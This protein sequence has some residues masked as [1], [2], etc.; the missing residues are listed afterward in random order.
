[1]SGR[2][3]LAIVLLVLGAGISTALVFRKDASTLDFR[4]D[5]VPESPFRERVERRALADTAWIR[6]LSRGRAKSV[7]R[8]AERITPTPAS[9][10]Q[11]APAPPTFQKSFS[12]VGALL[13]PIDGVPSDEQDTDTVAGLEPPSAPGT[14]IR[15]GALAHRVVDGDTLSQLAQTYLGRSDRYLEIFQ[16]NRDQL[17]SPDLLPIGAMLKIPPRQPGA[18]SNHSQPS[19]RSA[20]SRAQLQPLPISGG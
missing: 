17:A 12:P 19:S 5:A 11:G 9:M 2:K 20:E 10:S 3:R 7:E 16:A 1:M 18:E 4:Q 8:P 6:N 15:T 14:L 13:Y